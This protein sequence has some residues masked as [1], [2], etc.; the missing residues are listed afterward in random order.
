MAALPNP[1]VARLAQEG[2]WLEL[3]RGARLER[4]DRPGETFY[5]VLQGQLSVVLGHHAAGP[6]E[7]L[8]LF[9]SG[10]C[11]SDAYLDLRA[12]R[13]QP[14]VDCLAVVDSLLLGV[15]Q[16]ELVRLLAAHPEWERQ[17]RERNETLRVHYRGQALFGRRTVQS[18]FVEHDFSFATTM[19]VLQLDQCI[20]CDSCVRACTSRHGQPRFQRAG[21]RLGRLAFPV[22]CRTCADPACVSAC[23]FDAIARDEDSGEV[24]IGQKCQG[25]GGCAR[26]CPNGAITLIEVPYT[27][28]DF[29]TALPQTDLACETNVEGLFL[30]GEAAGEA[31]IKKAINAGHRAVEKL[32]PR[33]AGRRGE[34]ELDVVIIG[35]GPGGLSAALACQERGLRYAL[36]E[37]ETLASTIR[38]YPNKKFV[39]AEPAYLPLSGSLGMEDCSKEELLAKWEDTVRARGIEVREHEEVRRVTK[40]E[41]SLFQVETARASYRAPFVVL[42]T[43]NR[44]SPRRLGVAGEAPPRV[45]YVLTAPEELAGRRVLVVGGGDSAVE[46]AL[47]LADVPGTTVTLSYRR[48]GFSRIK[49]RNR[50]RIDEYAAAGQVRVV[51]KSTVTRLADGAVILAVEGTETTLEND[52]VFALLGAEPPT[53]FFQAAGINVIEPGTPAM[54]EFAASRGLRQRAVKCD[55]CAGFDE[56]ACLRVCPTGA[57]TEIAPSRVFVDVE[58]ARL[59]SR[60][61]FS[62]RPFLE[63][64][65]EHDAAVRGATRFY[66]VGPLLFLVLVAIGVECL[67]RVT[68]PTRSLLH[69]WRGLTGSAEPVTFAAGRGFGHLLGY[70]GTVLM[71]LALTYPLHSRWRKFQRLPSSTWL[72]VHLWTGLYGAALVT[73][74]SVLKLDRWV[75]L[76][77]VAT[78]IVVL[79]GAVGRFL[80]G[81]VH[82]GVGLAEFDQHSVALQHRRLVLEATGA[83]N[84]A[85]LAPTPPRPAPR[86]LLRGLG[87]M[88]ARAVLDRA[89][90]LWLR[91]FGL[92]H[93]ANR[94]LRRQQARFLR[95]LAR[96]ERAAANLEWS[97]VLLSRWNRLHL[98]LTLFMLALA[99][100]HIVF[101]FLYKAT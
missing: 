25:C 44:G 64:I 17:L 21:L 86:G 93:I 68:W 72:T 83:T 74:H 75:A 84:L 4:D 52:V 56:P 66:W 51:F 89:R 12:Q 98:I 63:G 19:R 39:M 16:P 101:A 18:F 92:R 55:H 47:S 22:A 53:R 96:S 73:Y 81:R 61:D 30:V 1:S 80:Y 5:L 62:E 40:V 28:G 87:T 69:L 59:G 43:G 49:P 90:F 3:R 76:S 85:V 42:A 24:S 11:I 35:A 23:A 41:R 91:H 31:L 2:R 67:L 8:A 34:T 78:W 14:Q 26:A 6:R 9:V 100:L 60:T 88:L 13:L 7:H 45:Q 71:L 29:P 70:V 20:S 48:D 54:E 36:L 32:R 15:P 77:L 57:L 58:A 37:K 79:S 33:A 97:R 95:D 94:A 50:A 65:A 38:Q 46:A 10:D 27:G 82:G 99:V